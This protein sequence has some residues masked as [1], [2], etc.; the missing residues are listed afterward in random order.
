MNQAWKGLEQ[1]EQTKGQPYHSLLL[2]KAQNPKARSDDLAQYFTEK[3]ARPISAANVRQLVH[4]GQ[5]CS[6]I[7]SWRKWPVRWPSRPTRK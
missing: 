2:Y 6:A 7:C 3:L 5:S 1:I 4:R